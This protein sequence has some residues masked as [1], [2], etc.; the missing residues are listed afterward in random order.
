MFTNRDFIERVMANTTNPIIMQECREM[1]KKEEDYVAKRRA[2][3]QERAR[4]IKDEIIVYCRSV[5]NLMASNLEIANAINRPESQ[6]GYYVRELI[7]DKEL[8]ERPKKRHNL[9]ECINDICNILEYGKIYTVIDISTIL[10]NK[11]H[12]NT[13]TR[14]LYEIKDFGE[15]ENYSIKVNSFTKDERR[16]GRNITVTYWIKA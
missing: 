4:K 8:P 5:N 9:Y 16:D 6:I 3:R 14:A 7:K 1:L 12:H 13:I 15:Y 2:E 11:Y 10:N